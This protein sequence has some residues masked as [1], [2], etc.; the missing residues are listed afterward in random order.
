MRATE[1]ILWSC[2]LRG[3]AARHL[4]PDLL[5]DGD[6]P[7]A[8]QDELRW[9]SGQQSSY[10]VRSSHKAE[11]S[12]SSYLTAF[13]SFTGCQPLDQFV[14]PSTAMSPD[15]QWKS[16]S[17]GPSAISRIPPPQALK[18]GDNT[19]KGT[20][21]VDAVV[22][23][24]HKSPKSRAFADAD[25]MAD[26]RLSSLAYRAYGYQSPLIGFILVLE[27]LEKHFK[28]DLADHKTSNYPQETKKDWLNLTYNGD[29][30]HLHEPNCLF[31]E[32]QAVSTIRSE[33]QII[34]GEMFLGVYRMPG[35][36]GLVA[37][38]VKDMVQLA[39]LHI[40][41]WQ[42]LKAGVFS[43]KDENC[44]LSDFDIGRIRSDYS[45]QRSMSLLPYLY[46]ASDIEIISKT[47]EKADLDDSQLGLIEVASECIRSAFQCAELSAELSARIYV[48]RGL[49]CKGCQNSR[50]HAIHE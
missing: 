43:W 12:S 40:N 48:S 1:S 27:S 5:F 17:Q 25:L 44:L 49:T 8:I 39:K 37:R 29:R 2:G 14:F 15:I 3:L 21:D 6:L 35:Y 7:K 10:I 38:G 36:S 24:N 41:M 34:Y 31:E 9:C 26:Q 32:P 13:W 22:C 45:K 42:L 16:A 11:R 33:L 4:G 20:R 18:Q 23:S 50:D 30:S 47:V 19:G 46:I 28:G